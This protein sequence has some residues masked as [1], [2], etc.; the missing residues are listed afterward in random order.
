[1]TVRGR[2]RRNL[3]G[4]VLEKRPELT[5][6]PLRLVGVYTHPQYD[7]T[8]PNGD[9][10]QQ[11]THL[12]DGAGHG[13][14]HAAG[15]RETSEQAFFTPEEVTRSRLPIWYAHMWCAMCW[16]VVR[17]P[18]T[19]LR[20]L[21]LWTKLGWY[22]QIH[23]PRPS[24]AVG[25]TVVW[26][27]TSVSSP[28]SA[29]TTRCGLC[30]PDIWARECGANG[31]TRN[32]RGNWLHEIAIE[33]LVGVYSGKDFQHTYANGD[34][35][36]NVGAIFKARLV[37]GQPQPDLAE[38]AGLRWQTADA[39]L[40]GLPSNQWRRYFKLVVQHLDDGSFVC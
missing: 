7:V 32:I 3:R 22:G 19:R 38:V 25:A 10:V 39:F 14:H 23:R 20:L 37:G 13:R 29:R 26:L 4:A 17:L 35:V 8:Y 40:V 6:G 34:V 11:F 12:P 24:G 31:R 15:R 30:R 27:K 33:R 1:M 21:K 16:R 28:S 36:Q 5:A 18:F 9:Q 2:G